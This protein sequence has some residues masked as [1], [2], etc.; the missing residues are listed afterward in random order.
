MKIEGTRAKEFIWMF[1][2]WTFAV[3]TAV[4]E[5]L[6]RSPFSKGES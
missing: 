4:Y 3:K 2:L 1:A 6:G 5:T